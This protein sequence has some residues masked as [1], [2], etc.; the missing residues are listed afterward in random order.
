MLLSKCDLGLVLRTELTCENGLTFTHQR[1]CHFY[2]RS[3]RFLPPI[4]APFP[5]GCATF[6]VLFV[7]VGEDITRSGMH[8][9]LITGFDL[10]RLP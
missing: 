5:A 1:D 8:A 4:S 10:L 2:L 3:F 9:R 7:K 6:E